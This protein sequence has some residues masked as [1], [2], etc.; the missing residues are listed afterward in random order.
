MKQ[1]LI[2]TLQIY[3]NKE[4][5]KEDSTDLIYKHARGTL[6]ERQEQWGCIPVSPSWGT[7]L[8]A[9]WIFSCFSE[10]KSSPTLINFFQLFARPH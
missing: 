1:I 5:F 3:Y 6:A 9:S 4:K 2:C 8:T 7:A 10:L